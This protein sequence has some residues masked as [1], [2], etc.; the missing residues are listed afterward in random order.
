MLWGLEAIATRITTASANLRERLEEMPGVTVH[1]KG[2]R[3]CGIVTFSVAGL[4]ADDVRRALSAER[5]N[6]W[7]S[8]RSSALLDM[9]NR[10]LDSIV[11]AS[12]HYY[13]SDDE[14]ERFCGLVARLVRV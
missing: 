1:D 5:V 6:V 14:I 10:K 4:D 7:V 8:R 9:D 2:Q 12:L 13:N 3:K 11:R